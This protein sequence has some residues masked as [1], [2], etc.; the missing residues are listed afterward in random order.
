MDRKRG[1]RRNEGRKEGRREVSKNKGG[2]I[3]D[4]K[5]DKRRCDIIE[6]EKGDKDEQP[7]SHRHLHNNVCRAPSDNLTLFC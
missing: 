7:A 6:V 5:A 3:T 4:E 2:V 1:G